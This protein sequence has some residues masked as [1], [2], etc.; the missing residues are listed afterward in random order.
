[1]ERGCVQCGECLNVCPVFMEFMREEYSPKAKR[2]LLEPV[3]AD[4]SPMPWR[5]VAALSRVCAGCD[6]CRQACARKLSTAELLADMRAKHPHWTQALWEI[7]IRRLGPLWPTIG[8]IATMMPDGITPAMLRASIESAKALVNIKNIQ[9]WAVVRRNPASTPDHSRVVV[10]AG[11]TAHNARPQWRSKAE[12]LLGAFGHTVLDGSG[13]TCCGGTL[14]H[15]GQ[16]AAMNEA[17]RHNHNYWETLG[18]PRIVALCASCFHGLE[19]YAGT[20]LKD[21]AAVAWKNSLTP[22]SVVLHDAISEI[23]VHKPAIYGYHA[24]CH[25]GSADPDMPFLA[26]IL[27]GLHKGAGIC[28]GMGGIL[29]MSNPDISA[30]MARRCLSGLADCGAVALTGCSGCV[31]QLAAA[32]KSGGSRAPAVHHWLDVLAV[33]GG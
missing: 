31:L 15:A 5:Q 21:D 33:W 26:K 29:K 32:G 14:R 6:R 28:C 25:W 16:Y 22:L 4:C 23:T 7:W 9:P 11:C 3:A 2:L 10:F 13:F 1:M 27:P 17:R 19:D 20:F 24:P 8:R 12:M 18:A 30:H